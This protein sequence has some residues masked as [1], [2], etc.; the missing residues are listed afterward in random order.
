MPKVKENNIRRKDGQTL[1]VGYKMTVTLRFYRDETL[2]FRIHNTTPR[3]HHRICLPVMNLIVARFGTASLTICGL[4]NI[5]Q[6][7]NNK[8]TTDTSHEGLHVLLHTF[9]APFVKYL[10]ERKMFGTKD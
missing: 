7:N 4:C 2:F 3:R 5:E 8:T 1:C 6:D 9:R 10:Q